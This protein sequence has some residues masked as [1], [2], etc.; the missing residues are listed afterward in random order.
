MT[1]TESLKKEVKKI[2]FVV[3]G[4]AKLDTLRDLPYGKIDYVGVLKSPE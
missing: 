3:S 4:I 2:G 1:L